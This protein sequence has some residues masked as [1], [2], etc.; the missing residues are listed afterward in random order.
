[1][2]VAS[3]WGQALEHT[4]EHLAYKESREYSHTEAWYRVNF[5]RSLMSFQ[6]CFTGKLLVAPI[7]F[8]WPNTCFVTL[9]LL[10]DDAFL[11]TG[12]RFFLFFCLKEKIQPKG[13]D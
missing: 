8:T 1:M 12:R 9:F 13:F 7:N 10:R 2:N 4:I 3:H 6:V 11:F 5:C